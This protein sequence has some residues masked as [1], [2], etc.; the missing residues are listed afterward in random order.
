VD[1]TS[2]NV[3]DVTRSADILI[4]SVPVAERAALFQHIGADVQEH[5]LVVDLTALKGPGLELAQAHLKQGYYVGVSPVLAAAVLSEGDSGVSAARADLFKDS[6]FCI[7][8]SGKLDAEAVKTTVNLGRILGA[9]PFFLDPDEYDSLV[10]GVVAM[11]GLVAAALFH[12]ISAATGW[13]DMLRFAG[14]T[15]AQS[16]AG[17]ENVDLVDLAYQDKAATLRWLDALL[18]ELQNLRRW[19]ADEDQE[20]LALIVEEIALDRG[21]WLQERSKNNWVEIEE[22]EDFGA[23]NIAGQMFGFGLRGKKKKSE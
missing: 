4:V 21:R 3:Q 7:M 18:A 20:R 8:A 1:K 22:P 17:L 11:P 9:T 13:R 12:S 10:K 14:P 6:V 19:L 16:T 23:T 5:T 15:F 2:R